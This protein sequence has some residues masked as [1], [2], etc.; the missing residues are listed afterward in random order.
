MRFKGFLGIMPI[1][2]GH[3]GLEVPGPEGYLVIVQSCDVVEGI[4]IWTGY[5][6]DT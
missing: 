4:R 2:L 1:S 3:L 6:A 5:P